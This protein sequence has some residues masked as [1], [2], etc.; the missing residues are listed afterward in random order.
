VVNAGTSYASVLNFGIP[1]GAT[2]T[3]GTVS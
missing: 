1:Q 2:G 3:N